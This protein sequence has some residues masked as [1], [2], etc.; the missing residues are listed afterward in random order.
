MASWSCP[1]RVGSRRRDS[2]RQSGRAPAGRRSRRRPRQLSPRLH[3]AGRRDARRTGAVNV[4]GIQR[5]VGTTP[6][7][8]RS[9]RRCPAL[10]AGDATFHYGGARG[11]DRH[12]LSR[13]VRSP[14]ARSG[15]PVRRAAASATRT[16]SS[17][18]AC[19]KRAGWCGSTPSWKSRTAR[20]ERCAALARQ[21][22]DYGRWKRVVVAEHPRSLRWR[23]AAPPLL[24]A[25]I[26]LASVIGVVRPR[27]PR[28]ARRLCR[29]GARGHAEDGIDTGEPGPSVGDLPDDAPL[30]GHRVPRRPVPPT[31]AVPAT[32]TGTVMSR[33]SPRH[34]RSGVTSR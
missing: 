15:R 31:L 27:V 3:A 25:T 4:G 24:T 32:A 16:T 34:R 17:T 28:R 6:F 11:A 14:G 5:A 19:G 26:A 23:Q 29:L 33:A 1:T 22:F 2:T 10:G 12:R 21:Y 7:E 18:S 13:G 30:V 9:P 20:A 8:R